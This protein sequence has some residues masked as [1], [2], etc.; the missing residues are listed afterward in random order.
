MNIG[1]TSK[2]K[3]YIN[4]KYIDTDN[5]SERALKYYSF[6][7]YHKIQPVGNAPEDILYNEYQ[8]NLDE[9]K[10]QAMMGC[11][12]NG[13]NGTGDWN[14]CHDCHRMK[15]ISDKIPQVFANLFH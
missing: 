12:H 5:N 6:T 7:P 11:I 13:L 2:T 9:R 4:L 8:I 1:V 15:N 10:L 3:R 14:N